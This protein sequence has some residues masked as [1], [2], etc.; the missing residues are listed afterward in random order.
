MI[1]QIFIN[2]IQVKLIQN[3]FTFFLNIATNFINIQRT[4]MIHII[5]YVSFV[6]SKNVQTVFPLDVIVISK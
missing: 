5:Q 2:E 4:F 6:Y 1:A 3:L